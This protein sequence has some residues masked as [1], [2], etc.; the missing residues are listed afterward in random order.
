MGGPGLTPS[1]SE[2]PL[3]HVYEGSFE[4]E[5]PLL[6]ELGISFGNIR[7]RTFAVL[8]PL[9]PPRHEGSSAVG[10]VC[11]SALALF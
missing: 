7:E 5:P 10:S 4:I 8:H 9:V 6:E 3:R 1:Y 2:A 11:A